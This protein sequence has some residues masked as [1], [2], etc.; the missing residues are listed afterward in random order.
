M[1][2]LLDIKYAFRLLAKSPL[3]TILTTIVLAG[4]LAVSI[5]SYSFLHTFVFSDLPLPEGESIVKLQAT[6]QGY[7]RMFDAVDF[8]AI[9]PQIST[10]SEYG[11]YYSTSV[12]LDING[13]AQSHNAT[14]S[15][16]NLFQ[17]S[18]RPTANGSSF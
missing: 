3:F 2:Y 9:R 16:W 12:L 8:A 11:M 10:L 4:G 1:N 15:E 17:F 18:P 14:F 5:F 13:Q 7:D 6:E